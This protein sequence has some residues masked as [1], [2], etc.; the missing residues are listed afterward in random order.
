MTIPYHY[1]LKDVRHIQRFKGRALIANEMGL[2][3]TFEALLWMQ[4]N[5]KVRP[6][7][8]VCPA[9][10][11]WNWEHEALTHIN[12]RSEVLEGTKPP[13]R[14]YLHHEMVII[15]YDILRPWMEYLVSLKAQLLIIDE[16]QY[17]ADRKT[18]RTRAV[19][20]LSKNTPHILAL[21]GTPLVNRPAELWPTLNILN[22]KEFPSF[23]DYALHHC[24]AKRNHW[25]WEFKGA[26]HLDELHQ[27]LLTTCGMI[28]HLKSDVL[29]ELPEKI[30]QILLLP[31]SK[32]KFYQKA[33][34]NFLR[35]L[36]ENQPEKLSQAAKA[37]RLV[38]MGY[39]K[40][41]AANLKLKAVFEWIDTF[42]AET[43]GKLV[44]YGIHHKI[45]RPLHKR[46]NNMSV[47][48]DGAVSQN[49]RRLAVKTF[50]RKDSCR[51]FFGNIRAAGIGLNLT[52]ATT[53]AFA[54]L[55]WTPGAHKQAEDRIHRIGQNLQT[56]C[57]YLVAKDT[58]EEK[59]VKIIQNK[60]SVSNNT[61]DGQ[62]KGDSLAIFDLLCMELL[63]EKT[64]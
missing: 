54:E 44:I 34:T 19:K 6:V 41:L 49:Q 52:S 35:W 64:N 18:K 17:L 25:G 38:R 61:L 53:M 31:I 37:E 33:S 62:G 20:E 32:P 11:K 5:P 46:Y 3:K 40:R 39:L 59:L 12:Q 14:F 28:R 8:V 1:Q 2:G 23:F 42:L 24:G 43:E 9:S 36:A 30:R 60:Q 63:K 4:R 10:L 56:S 57:Y 15:N 26:T 50:Q 58:I 22:S 13:E 48:I 55:D 27:R 16:S 21:S 45:L 47:L 29:K 7:I 51:L